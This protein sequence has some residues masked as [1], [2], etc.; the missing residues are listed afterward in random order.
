MNFETIK[1]QVSFFYGRL[2]FSLPLFVQVYQQW[3]FWFSLSFLSTSTNCESF[4]F[5]WRFCPSLPTV[6]VLVFIGIFVQVYQRQKFW[7]FWPRFLLLATLAMNTNGEIFVI[8]SLP[9][10][11]LWHPTPLYASSRSPEAIS[12][13]LLWKQEFVL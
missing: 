5:Y 8:W 12:G 7:L 6:K 10:S 9:M 1:C 11:N 4:G 2:T 13:T 3:K